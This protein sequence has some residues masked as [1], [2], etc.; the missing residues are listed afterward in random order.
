M[1][2]LLMVS[3]DFYPLK[4]V[5]ERLG[6]S[7]HD[8]LHLGIQGKAQ[9]C[10]NIYGMANGSSRERLFN[11]SDASYQLALTDEEKDE[12]LEHDLKHND[13]LNRTTQDMPDGI[14]EI[15]VDD[16]RFIDM[17]GS[18][19]FELYEAMKF[20]QNSWWFVT[21]DT[22]VTI[23]L[24]HLCLLHEELERLDPYMEKLTPTVKEIKNISEQ[25]L[26]TKL[27][28]L[29]QAADKFWKYADPAE[30]ETHTKN[31]IVITWLIE[32]GL[33]KVSARQGATIIRPEWAAKGNY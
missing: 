23:N 26:S 5:S 19:F 32:K 31:E 12:A 18:L 30:K 20:F 25:H 22:P 33:S 24:A 28:L 13:W 14:F 27:I 15:G 29:M 7:M 17:P 2:C 21:F 3:R 11:D 6:C 8:I 10:V 16:L 9:I 1:E 4:I